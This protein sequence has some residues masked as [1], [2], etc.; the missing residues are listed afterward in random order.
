[1]KITKNILALLFLLISSS[2]VFADSPL[3]STEFY[4]AYSNE[5]IIKES[6]NSNGILTGNLMIYLADPLQP[7]DVKMALI[8]RLGWNAKGKKNSKI[9]MKYLIKKYG[10]KTDES[11]INSM[12]G[13]DL[14]CLAYIKAMDNYFDVEK[15]LDYSNLAI[16]KSPNSFTTNIINALLKSQKFQN[17]NSCKVYQVLEDVRVNSGLKNDFKKEATDVIFEYVIMY[18]KYCK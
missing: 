10:F 13:E 5:I 11:L 7:I 6:A 2:K 4:K 12:S 15:A 17:N 9:F 18:K 8:N 1:M 3:T 14:T 16:K